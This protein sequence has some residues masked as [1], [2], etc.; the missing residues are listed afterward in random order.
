MG[1]STVVQ[2]IVNHEDLTNFLQHQIIKLDLMDKTVKLTSR[3]KLINMTRVKTIN[4]L[5]VKQKQNL[6]LEA[7]V[8]L[9]GS[10]RCYKC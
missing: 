4:N 5:Q 8:M 9:S 7:A 6:A 1:I 2:L 10:S 3:I